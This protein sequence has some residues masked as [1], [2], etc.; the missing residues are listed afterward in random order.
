MISTGLQEFSFSLHQAG[1]SQRSLQD[2]WSLRLL[3][4]A[5]RVTVSKRLRTGDVACSC[6]LN[7]SLF[8]ILRRLPSVRGPSANVQEAT[9]KKRESRKSGFFNLIKSRTSRSEKN[10][11]AAAVTPPPPASSTTPS[12]SASPVT[13][14]ATRASPTPPVKSPGTAAEPQQE[15]RRA[16]TPDHTDSEM[17][18]SPAAAEPAE[19]EQEED[20]VEKENPHIP[21]HIGVPVMGMDLLAEMKAR[22]ERMAGKKVGGA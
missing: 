1:I 10:H 8:L 3:E 16:Q 21:R 7:L 5:H 2:S 15:L 13:V 11:G 17:E 9:D 12:S 14:E 4:D 18:A 22:Q 6:G 19:E 20:D